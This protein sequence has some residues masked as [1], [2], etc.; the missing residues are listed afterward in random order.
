MADNERNTPIQD[1][2]NLENQIIDSPA[3]E[4]PAYVDTPEVETELVESSDSTAEQTEEE[5]ESE[6]L[7]E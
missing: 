2:E 1:P 5:K 6:M 7:K 4:V 3:E